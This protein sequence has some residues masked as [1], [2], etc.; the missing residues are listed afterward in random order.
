MVMHGLDRLIDKRSGP[1]MQLL[2]ETR[3][4]AE[5][6]QG[7]MDGSC[8]LPETALEGPARLLYRWGT[9]ESPRHL[10]DRLPLGL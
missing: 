6:G 3:S 2:Q 5:E 1:M 10:A 8:S 7:G 9:P 4:H